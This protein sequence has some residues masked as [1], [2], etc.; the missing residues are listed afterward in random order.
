MNNK[1]AYISEAWTSKAFGYTEGIDESTGSAKIIL[2]GD[3]ISL[4]NP[5]QSLSLFRLPF[6]SVNSWLNIFNESKPYKF[7]VQVFS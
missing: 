3:E 5:W 6:K 7:F 2:E 4:M 1:K